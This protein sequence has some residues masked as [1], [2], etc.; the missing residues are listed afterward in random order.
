MCTSAY[1]QV[2]EEDTKSQIT[3]VM[4]NCEPQNMSTGIQTRVLCKSA[5]S[6]LTAESSPNTEPCIFRLMDTADYS[7]QRIKRDP[8]FEMLL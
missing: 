7:V 2:P 5:K 3:I 6:F 8:H 4:G 1:V